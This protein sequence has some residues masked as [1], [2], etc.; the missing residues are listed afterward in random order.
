MTTVVVARAGGDEDQDT[1]A[2]AEKTDFGCMARAEPTE[3]AEASH[4]KYRKGRTADG[5]IT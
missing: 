3:P 5:D 2:E 1:A 4:E